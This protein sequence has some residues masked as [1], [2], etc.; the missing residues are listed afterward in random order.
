MRASGTLVLRGGADDVTTRVRVVEGGVAV[1]LRRV[2]VSVSCKV[3]KPH[4][5]PPVAMF[6]LERAP[7][8]RGGL[9]VGAHFDCDFNA[10]QHRWRSSRLP[11]VHGYFTFHALDVVLGLVVLEVADD[12]VQF[13]LDATT[14]DVDCYGVAARP[15]SWTGKV[16]LPRLPLASLWVPS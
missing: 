14:E 16:K 7:L 15:A 9:R 12:W 10:R 8:P 13:Q 4:T 6:C 1:E 3:K 2:T 5:W 11:K